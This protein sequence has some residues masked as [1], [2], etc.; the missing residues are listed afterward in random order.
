LLGFRPREGDH[1]GR[2]RHQYSLDSE[3]IIIAQE[4]QAR[5]SPRP[6]YHYALILRAARNLL[7]LTR[8][9]LSALSEVS[10]PAIARIEM[11]ETTPRA[12]TWRVLLWTLESFGVVVDDDDPG[13]VRLRFSTTKLSAAEEA[14]GI[15]ADAT[16]RRSGSPR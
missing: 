2:R 5:K 13:D 4:H 12:S 6:P 15:H 10:V 14:G 1:G 16:D 3:D 7:G 9:D 8:K 11:G